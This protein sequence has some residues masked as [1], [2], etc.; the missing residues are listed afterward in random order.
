MFAPAAVLALLLTSRPPK[1]VETGLSSYAGIILS[2][3]SPWFFELPAG[4][5]SRI[6]SSLTLASSLFYLVFMGAA[7]A[8]LG[9]NLGVLP[10]IK[11]LVSDGPYSLVR[12]PVYSSHLFLAGTLFAVNPSPWNA[13]ACVM[14]LSGIL[15]RI[16]AEE[17]LLSTDAAYRDYSLIVN[18]RI[19]TPALAAPLIA[20]VL[21]KCAEWLTA[22]PEAPARIR[23]QTSFPILSL[24]PRIYDDW[25]SVFI[26]NH[27]YP[28]LL[29]EPEREWI[30]SITKEVRFECLDRGASPLSPCKKERLLLSFREFT[31][32]RG[33]AIDRISLRREMLTILQAKNWILPGIKVCASKEFDLCLEYTG[34]PD[35]SRRLQNVYFRFGWSAQDFSGDLVGVGPYCFKI[36]QRAPES[37]LGGSLI[38]RSAA[39]LPRVDVAT[40][41]DPDAPF[42]VALFGAPNLLKGGRRN[43]DLITPVAYYVVSN[44]SFPSE[45]FPWNAPAIKEIIRAQLADNDLVYRTDTL[46]SAWMPEGSA[47]NRSPKAASASASGFEFVLPDYLPDCEPLAKRLHAADPRMDA[48]CANTTLYIEDRIRSRKSPWFGF[49]TPL[50]PGAPGR[51]SVIDQYF[52][53]GSNES[54]LRGAR[55]P[56]SH[57]YRVGLGKA[58]VTVD[59]RIVCGITGNPM[60]QSDFVV[61][62][63]IYCR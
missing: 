4:H 33:R 19:M 13:L 37:I 2:F 45:R 3:A 21:L 20:L 46:L 16:Q 39:N 61:S 34:I 6:A 29:P 54:W 52:S 31:S 59:Q 58:L 11:N 47:L 43:I 14:L 24:D 8:A 41:D 1:R 49:L 44:P 12:H 50:S 62:D 38:P 60:G 57:F 9:R 17:A 30:P 51:T 35:V 27:I 63:L 42:N 26:G 22:V 48:R 36:E 53:S 5:A 18:H 40:S 56:S 32:C 7:Y 15:L 23:L 10:S 25:A 28:R 55:S